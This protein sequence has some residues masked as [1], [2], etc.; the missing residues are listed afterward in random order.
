M[1]NQESKKI[2]ENQKIKGNQNKVKG[3]VSRNSSEA[4]DEKMCIIPSKTKW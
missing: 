1:K 2:K 3:K 4:C